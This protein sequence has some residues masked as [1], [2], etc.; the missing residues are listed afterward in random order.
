MSIFNAS[1]FL[2][3]KNF[4]INE[5][6]VCNTSL[7]YETTLIT[8]SSLK[9]YSVMSIIS[10]KF[11]SNVDIQNKGIFVK[12]IEIHCNEDLDTDYESTKQHQY[13]TFLSESTMGILTNFSISQT[14]TNEINTNTTVSEKPSAPIS[15]IKNISIIIGIC[16]GVVYIFS[17]AV[18]LIVYL[19][20]V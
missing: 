5:N 19:L 17:L 2:S 13:S 1:S 18:F 3:S 7:K 10:F 8:N 16:V 4:S 14:T 20:R 6:F 15:K 12:I 11:I 9:C